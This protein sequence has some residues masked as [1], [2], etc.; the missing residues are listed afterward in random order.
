M[1]IKHLFILVLIIVVQ[2]SNSTCFAINK[3]N[4]DGIIIKADE[5]VYVNKVEANQQLKKLPKGVYKTKHNNVLYY[6]ADGKFYTWADTVY[7]S[8]L[9]PVGIFVKKLPVN[10]QRIIKGRNIY[11]YASGIYYSPL[12]KGFE[13]T[14]A[15]AGV[16]INNLNHEASQIKI[17]NTNYYLVYNTIY[18]KEST[19]S[20]D[21]YVVVGCVTN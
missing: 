16:E 2:N 9:P 10:Y 18:K 21:Y 13:V 20:R 19:R 4:A 11:Y 3:N 15:Q 1:R 17:N 6:F 14:Y 5:I 8:V 7:L 12:K